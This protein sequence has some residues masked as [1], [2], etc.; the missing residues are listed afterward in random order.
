[1]SDNGICLHKGME[2]VF[3]LLKIPGNWYFSLKK[4]GMRMFRQK[5]SKW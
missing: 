5:V 2:M 1:M 3:D 4:S